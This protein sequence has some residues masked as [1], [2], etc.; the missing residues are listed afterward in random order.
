MLFRSDFV[1]ISH[2]R[3]S[4]DGEWR[5]LFSR[6]ELFII[7]SWMMSQMIVYT[8]LWVLNKKM[9]ASSNLCTYY[10]KTLMFWACEEKP[11]QFWRDDL[12]V[13]SV[14]ELLIEMI[15]CVKSKFC[16]NYF[17]PGN[18]MIDHLIDTDLSYETDNLYKILESRQLISDVVDCRRDCEMKIDSVKDYFK[19]PAWITRAMAIY[20]RI[21]NILDNHED[22][23]TDLKPD[24]LCALNVELS[25]IY[26]AL[27]YQQKSVSSL[28]VSDK[29]I[30]FLKAESH[31]L[32]AS[33]LYQ[34][35]EDY[36]TDNGCV[37]LMNLIQGHEEGMSGEYIQA[38][39]GFVNG[40]FRINVEAEYI[41]ICLAC[42]QH[43]LTLSNQTLKIVCQTM[44][45][46]NLTLKRT[47]QSVN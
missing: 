46:L 27:R 30:Y 20:C 1:Q 28:N 7:N 29:H 5:F 38:Y 37:L 4:N 19:F 40:G 9:I 25:D 35:C 44:N 31:L 47:L 26:R 12:L 8:T 21:I 24:L 3:L 34:S 10:F 36:T 23:F 6:A 42:W 13:E 15:K 14:C 16:V 39:A 33:N 17:I 45:Q 18:N 32:L 22:L 11:A 43:I 2:N 41:N